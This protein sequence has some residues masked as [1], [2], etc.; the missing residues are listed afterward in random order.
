MIKMIKTKKANALESHVQ[1][2]EDSEGRH[3]FSYDENIDH[4]KK[5]F[6]DCPDVIMRKTVL[7]KDKEGYF[8]YI[9]GLIDTDLVQRDFI[10]PIQN[11]NYAILT[12]KEAL[13]SLPLS[14]I[15]FLDDIET[16]I[17]DIMA[18]NTLFICQGLRYAISCSLI[19]FDK[20]SVEEPVTE[21]NIK[22]SHEGFV[23]HIT[24]NMTIL[25]RRIKN[26]SLKFRMFKLGTTTNQTVAVAYI[27]DIA[28]P[29][30]LEILAGKIEA[31][32]FDGLIGVGYIEQFICDHPNSPFPQYLSTERPDKVVASLLEGKFII[33]LDGTPVVSIVPV[34]FAGFFQAPDDYTTNWMFGTFVGIIR[35]FGA[36]VAVFLPGLY[37][38]ILSFHYY[39]VPLTLLISLAES[40]SRVPFQ[41][42]I[43]A[44]IMEMTLELLRE[45]TIRL[46]T[47][48]GTAVGVVGGLI[49]GQ[50]A[51]QAGLVSNLMVIVVAL[52]GIASFVIPSYDMGLAI[53]LLRFIVMLLAAVFGVIGIVIAATA[54][55]AHLLSIE[56]LGQP[57]FSPLVPFK[58]KDIKDFFIRLP[59]QSFYTRPDTAQPVDK[60]RGK[61]NG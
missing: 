21:K 4:L 44:L 41:P 25:R 15:A 57:Y 14:E 1:D 56:S 61:S 10:S 32:N 34:D 2:Q 29:S 53:R 35:L 16:I 11:M 33:I 23:E 48:I 37:I 18:G 38:S 19:K 5:V 55:I 20:R 17:S 12:E 60:K 7:D 59:L 24:T 40:R 47:Y 49:I 3:I 42:V 58:F 26:P 36:I 22:G 46:P 9:D 31:I 45:A 43:E 51:V 50:A 27:E 13:E 30:L 28:N 39:T 52:T 54:I 8:I 6:K